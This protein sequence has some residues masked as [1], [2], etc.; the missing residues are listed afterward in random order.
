[1]AN[2]PDKSLI[3]IIK[4][5]D[6]GKLREDIIAFKCKGGNSYRGDNCHIVRGYPRDSIDEWEEVTAV[7]TATLKRLQDAFRGIYVIESLEPPLLEVLSHLPA[8]KPN[9]LDRAAALA[10]KLKGPRVTPDDTT[11]RRLAILLEAISFTHASP[12][13]VD[14][15]TEIARTCADWLYI[16]NP[17]HVGL[18]DI[19]TSAK[20]IDRIPDDEENRYMS[21]TYRFA[22]A[23]TLIGEGGHGGQE[24]M[25]LGAYALAWAAQ[26]I[27]EEDK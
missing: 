4:G 16:M 11:S 8:D 9:A 23:A 24:I 22:Q 27:E 20:E 5:Y 19:E 2:W 18:D 26:I 14:E 21:L 6:S 25:E 10:R 3:R 17:N 1:M 13:K 7:P 12:S 15:L